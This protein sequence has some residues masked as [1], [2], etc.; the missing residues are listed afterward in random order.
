MA[1]VPANALQR[2]MFA[3]A[4]L[5]G[6]SW[7]AW[8][9]WVAVTACGGFYYAID[10]AYIHLAMA[11]NLAETGTYGVAPHVFSSASSSPAWTVGLGLTML[12][13]PAQLALY[14]PFVLA[15]CCSLGACWL[16]AAALTRHQL[17]TTRWQA[18]MAVLLAALWP[19]WLGMPTLALGGMEHPVHLLVTMLIAWQLARVVQTG[20]GV[21]ALLVLGFLTPLVRFES[22]API[23]AAAGVLAYTKRWRL[24]GGLLALAALA[25][26]TQGLWSVAH[27]ESWLPNSVLVK[28][29]IHAPHA[30][31]SIAAAGGQAGVA[32]EAP[33]RFSQLFDLLLVILNRWGANIGYSLAMVVLLCG[34]LALA[35]Y[36]AGRAAFTRG[37]GAVLA[38]FLGTFLAQTAMV[39]GGPDFGRYQSYLV[40]I[41]LLAV[42][43][44]AG[45]LVLQPRQA[46]WRPVALGGGVVGALV[47]VFLPAMQ[48]EAQ[49]GAAVPGV[50]GHVR[51]AEFLQEVAPTGTLVGEDLGA[52]VWWRPAPV[53]DVYGLASHEIALHQLAGDYDA[54]VLDKLTRQ[55]GA[56]IAAI[57]HG[58][59]PLP[60]GHS[61]GQRP[62]HWQAVGLY[63]NDGG[64]PLEMAM[65]FFATEPGAVPRLR[66]A[67]Q[68]WRAR[69]VH[70]GRVILMGEPGTESLR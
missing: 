22:L 30:T 56:Q 61:I 15:V 45:E 18:A 66:Q 1:A 50:L 70:P 2:W 31:A 16:I 26:L 65:G 52:L 59:M 37:D 43:W 46:A 44:L 6:G 23:C 53:L 19:V 8:Q 40:G 38:V 13:T 42:A 58:T 11:R 69:G 63:A 3:A 39:A 5:G 25:M 68:Q 41:G 12:L 20:D 34:A 29:H 14:V 49:A 7:M 10:D 57:R 32:P 24:A 9:L 55:Q 62:P 67:L 64:A 35:G 17:A 28:M 4:V 60:P 27:G 36:R 47:I 33:G 21:A 54:N 51:V 48:R